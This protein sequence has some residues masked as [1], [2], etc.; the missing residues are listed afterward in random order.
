MAGLERYGVDGLLRSIAVATDQRGRGIGSL[1]V[2]RVQ[3]AASTSGLTAVYLLTS[4]AESYFP[5]FSFLPI[6]RHVVPTPMYAAP[7]FA[8]ICP[9]SAKCLRWEPRFL[10][11]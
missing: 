10:L 8:S 2:R 4:T 9:D 1:L 6:P 5:R 7:E 11:P 3:D